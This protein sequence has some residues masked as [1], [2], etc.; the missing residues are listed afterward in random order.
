MAGD[1]C[2]RQNACYVMILKQ[3]YE[4]TDDATLNIGV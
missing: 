2:M 1:K 4:V 3:I